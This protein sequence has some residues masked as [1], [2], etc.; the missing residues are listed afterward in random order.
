[1]SRSPKDGAARLQNRRSQPLTPQRVFNRA[2][3]LTQGWYPAFPSRRLKRGQCR[4]FDIL[5]QRL[6]VYRGTSGQTYALDAFCPHLG[7]DLGNGRVR[8]EH[9][10]CYFHQWEL[11]PSGRVCA[12]ACR[13][14]QDLSADPVFQNVGNRAYATA[15]GYGWIW[16]FAGPAAEAPPLPV[17]PGFE[18]RPL[19]ALDLGEITLY[20]HPHI[21]MAN[22]VDLQHFGAVHGLDMAFDYQ[23]EESRP[24]VFDWRLQGQIPKQGIKGR[25]GR[26]L[27]GETFHY[28]VRFAGGSVISITY[29]SE[30]YFRGRR[31]PSLQILWGCTPLP[32]GTGR[33]RIFLVAPRRKGLARLQNAG[34]YLLTA[35]LI[36]LLRDEDIQ[37]FPH[38]RFNT[39]RLLREDQSLAK[40]ISLFNQLPLSDW[41]EPDES[42]LLQ[43]PQQ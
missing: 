43:E 5:Q 33:A 13:K 37:A 38:M 26:W 15:E 31:L 18:D 35:A 7:A 34:L 36:T 17:P 28:R 12:V 6:V 24:G 20:V 23:I 21:M 30:Q 27:L 9:I 22:A 10:Q 2:G 19:S 32:N 41:G 39:G 4:S 11:D 42:Q 8:G 40:L 16:V 29:G 14:G 25:L 3:V 1:M